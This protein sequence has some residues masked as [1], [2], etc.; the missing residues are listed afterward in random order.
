MPHEMRIHQGPVGQKSFDCFF[1]VWYGKSTFIAIDGRILCL[2]MSRHGLDGFIPK[3]D[4]VLT[5][6]SP[7]HPA[8]DSSSSLHLPLHECAQAEPFNHYDFI[9]LAG[10]PRHT[11]IITRA[12]FWRVRT[13]DWMRQ[14]PP[15]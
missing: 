4:R 9:M 12:V 13:T 10:H 14:T 5:M 8:D 6:H 15:A 2:N 1:G 7:R 11:F 3:V